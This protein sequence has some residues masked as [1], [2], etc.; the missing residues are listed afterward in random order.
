YL[1]PVDADIQTEADLEDVAVDVNYVLGQM[2]DA[3]NAL[4]I[5]IL[6]ACR[7]NPFVRSFRSAQEGLAQLRAPTGTLIAYATAP[8]SVAADGSGANSPYAEELTRQMEASGVV[9]ETMFRRVTEQVSS[10]TGGRQ[11]PWISDNHKGEFYFSSGS[12]RAGSGS[13]IPHEP[14]PSKFDPNAVELTYWDSIKNSTD[15]EDFKAYLEKYPAGQFA[16]LARNN[17]RRLGTPKVTPGN[18]STS[19]TGNVPDAS[20]RDDIKTKNDEISRQ[21]AR[22]VEINATITRTFKAGNDALI[23]K[24]YDE[25]IRQY[26]EGLASDAE[27]AALWTNKAQALK[28]RGIGRYNSAITGNPAAKAAGLDLAKADFRAAVD[29]AT[30]AV[31]LVKTQPAGDPA[32]EGRRLAALSVQTES[33]RLFVSKFDQSLADTADAAYREYFTVETDPAKK[34]KAQVDCAQMFFDSGDSEKAY[35]KF[36]E[37]LA[38]NSN[39]LQ[40]NLGAGMALF[41]IGDKAR[42]REAATYVKRFIDLAPDT[43]PLKADAKEILKAIQAP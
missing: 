7:N 4:N 30:K 28:A 14:S 16:A 27:Q 5:A 11:E 18:N 3:Q 24:N 32:A 33:L 6:D 38:K 36:R 37:V 35:S 43:N 26:D 34:E 21:N 40:A 23:A 25:A 39:H 10:R 13:P 8:D 19:A 17:L 1:V 15:S 42:F 31:Q 2:E 41:A 29:A 20:R 12:S 9:L 22:N